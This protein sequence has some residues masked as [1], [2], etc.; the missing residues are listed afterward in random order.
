MPIKGKYFPSQ[1][2]SEKVFLLIRRHWVIFFVIFLFI[3]ILLVPVVILIIYWLANPD[4]FSGPLGN[5]V[6]IFSGMY[7]LSVVGL[8]LYGFVNYYLDVYI[9]TNKRIVDIQQKGFFRREIAELHLHQIQDVEARV[10]GFFQTLMHFGDIYIQTAGERENFVFEDV[11]HPYTLAKE[12]VE[13]H[14]AQIEAECEPQ[15]HHGEEKVDDYRPEDYFQSEP[16]QSAQMGIQPNA[17]EVSQVKE[18]NDVETKD[19]IKYPEENQQPKTEEKIIQVATQNDQIPSK[20]DNQLM[21]QI[22]F[23]TEDP[24]GV[25]QFNQDVK[26]F[27]EGEE[28]SLEDKNQ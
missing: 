16:E 1:E 9:V 11:P 25:K 17:Q 12:I 3:F 22:T 27:Y 28:V 10:E 24:S 21:E 8:S 19:E 7:A 4:T 23:G 2:S 18:T 14:E 13:L 5:F 6:I 20:K 26:Q 15:I